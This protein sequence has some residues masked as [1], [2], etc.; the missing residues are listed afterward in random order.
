MSQTI[1]PFH[2]L[3][4]FLDK[5]NPAKSLLLALVATASLQDIRQMLE[6]QI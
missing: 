2:F 1:T 6:I 4:F 3:V 5:K